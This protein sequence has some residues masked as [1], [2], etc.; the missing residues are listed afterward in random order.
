MSSHAWDLFP[1]TI[2]VSHETASL[3]YVNTGRLVK[4]QPPLVEST[5][6]TEILGLSTRTHVGCVNSP[7]QEECYF[8][9]LRD[10][11]IA[12]P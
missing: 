2:A 7:I 8:Q 1:E 4:I 5:Y 11:F 12:D 10:A 6:F 3:R 9:V